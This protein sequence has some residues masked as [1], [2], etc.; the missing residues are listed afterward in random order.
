KF[1]I[2]PTINGASD[3]STNIKDPRK[4]A[5]AAVL[6]S[7]VATNASGV[8]TNAG[9]A[10][11]SEV[12]I[13]STTGLPLAAAVTLTFDSTLNQFNVSAPPGGTLAYNPAT[14]SNGKQFSLASIGNATF[15]LSGNPAN[16][17]Q[18]IIENNANASGDNQNGLK[19][20]NLQTDNTLLGG[21]SSYQDSYGQLVAE[22][23]TT[24]RQTQISSQALSA[25][26]N[27]A[28]TARDSVSGVNLEEEAGNMLKYQQAFQAAAQMVNTADTLFQSLM[29]ALN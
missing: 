1:V 28:L 14:D 16:G 25:L 7:S 12:D 10:A 5:V 17:D 23:G 8:P 29:Q 4:I 18:F 6:R 22:V 19:L 2:R 11:I 26:R 27:Q 9:N 20:S 21:T 24:T 13:S 15:S 3:I